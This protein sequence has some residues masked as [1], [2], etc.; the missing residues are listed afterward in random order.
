LFSFGLVEQ[1]KSSSFGAM[2]ASVKLLFIK[3]SI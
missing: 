2:R 1:G 3:M